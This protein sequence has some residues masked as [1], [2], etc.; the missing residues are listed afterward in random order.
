M[1]TSKSK[2]YFFCI[3]LTVLS[4]VLTTTLATL[5]FQYDITASSEGRVTSPNFPN[6]YPLDSEFIYRIETGPYSRLYVWLNILSI[7]GSPSTAYV[8]AYSDDTM[9][10]TLMSPYC[11]GPVEKVIMNTR[12]VIL[13]FKTDPTTS[14]QGFEAFYKD[15]PNKDNSINY[16]SVS[17]SGFFVIT[18]SFQ[19][20]FF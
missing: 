10:N 18:F 15:F 7:G 9:T 17:N 12:Y 19:T 13:K 3:V 1:V 6:D 2:Q 5:T 16:G 8:V 14:G 11:C 20:F 4:T